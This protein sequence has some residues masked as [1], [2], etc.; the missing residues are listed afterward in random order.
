MS[1]NTLS[2][3]FSQWD[4]VVWWFKTAGGGGGEKEDDLI[5]RTR[6][7]ICPPS[8]ETPVFVFILGGNAVRMAYRGEIDREETD[9]LNDMKQLPFKGWLM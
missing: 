3:L 8:R 5:T 4:L 9:K 7:Q 1:I 6:E 2:D